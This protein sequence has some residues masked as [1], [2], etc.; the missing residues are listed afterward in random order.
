MI[1]PQLFKR[2]TVYGEKGRSA[3]RKRGHGQ[4]AG[5][6]RSSALI[7][8]PIRA[9]K[10]KALAAPAT[11]G[12]PPLSTGAPTTTIGSPSFTATEEPKNPSVCALVLVSVVGVRKPVEASKT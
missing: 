4:Q 7:R 10:T 2:Y 9:P 6:V 11:A 8:Q 5:V 1:H 12:V 3:S